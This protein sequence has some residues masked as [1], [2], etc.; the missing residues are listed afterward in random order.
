MRWKASYA[1]LVDCCNRGFPFTLGVWLDAGGQFY[2]FNP[3]RVRCFVIVCALLGILFA[4]MILIWK[5]RE[6]GIASRGRQLN[7]QIPSRL[8]RVSIAWT[9]A[10]QGGLV[11][12]F[13]G[14]YCYH[15]GWTAWLLLLPSAFLPFTL[16]ASKLKKG[17]LCS[18]GARTFEW[19]HAASSAS[20][21]GG[22]PPSSIVDRSIP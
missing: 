9:L 8:K 3:N 18:R 4:P 21:F 11:I 7:F 12:L 16:F 5:F 1:Q 20:F 13:A 14:V 15:F 6:R 19:R 17:V 22:T 2:V 10:V